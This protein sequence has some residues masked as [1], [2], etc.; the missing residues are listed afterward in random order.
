MDVLLLLYSGQESPLLCTEYVGQRK[1]P[2]Q[3]KAIESQ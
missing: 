3:G 2:L 1:I